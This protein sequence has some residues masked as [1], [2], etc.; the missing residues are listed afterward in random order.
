MGLGDVDEH[1]GG[2]VDDVEELHDGG[3][4][5]GDSGVAL[6][7]VDELVHAPGAE[8]GADGV[9]DDGAGVDVA[10]QLGLTLGCVGPFLEK[11]DLGL[12]LSSQT[13]KG[14]NHRQRR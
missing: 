5:V 2:R 14:S 3:A 11:Y 12:L 7:V 13:A 6:V 8:G 1:L 10:H 4:V 9:G